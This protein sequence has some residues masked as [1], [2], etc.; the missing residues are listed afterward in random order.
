MGMLTIFLDKAENLAN[1]DIGTG[2]DPYVRFELEQ[3]NWVSIAS[4][5]LCATE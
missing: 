5:L 3:D 1:T 4:C 2:S